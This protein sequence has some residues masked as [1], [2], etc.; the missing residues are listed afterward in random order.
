MTQGLGVTYGLS[1]GIIFFAYAALF[2]LGAWLI[3]P[4]AEGEPAKPEK[5]TF[6][7]M[8]MYVQRFILLI[9]LLLISHTSWL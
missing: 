5:L 8:M 3:V 9:L 1:Q 7:S 2:Y 6:E 4:A